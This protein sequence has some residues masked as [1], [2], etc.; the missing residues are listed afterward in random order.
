MK[1]GGRIAVSCVDKGR[2][3]KTGREG[4]RL[5]IRVSAVGLNRELEILISNDI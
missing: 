1:C 3:E 4:N 5:G 2:R